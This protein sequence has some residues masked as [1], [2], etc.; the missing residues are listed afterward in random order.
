[1]KALRYIALTLV[2]IGALNWGLVGFF[3]FDFIAWL[4]GGDKA[5]LS[6]ILY[7]LIGLSGLWSFRC[8]SKK[9]HHK[10]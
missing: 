1:M 6:R 7:A 2:I 3:K 9:C 5:A 10:K 8:Y 4:F